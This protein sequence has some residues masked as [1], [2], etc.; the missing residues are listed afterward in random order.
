MM[1]VPII[2]QYYTKAKAEATFPLIEADSTEADIRQSAWVYALD[3]MRND[4]EVLTEAFI[5][6]YLD[7]LDDMRSYHGAVIQALADEDY[8]SMGKLVEEAVGGL[9][10]RTV[11]YIEEH[12]RNLE[13]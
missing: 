11:D 7:T 2:F 3:L 12:I 9:I 13:V 1:D 10:N 5:G 4:P 6:E 8:V